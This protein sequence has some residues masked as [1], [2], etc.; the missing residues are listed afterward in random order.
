[1]IVLKIFSLNSEGIQWN[2]KYVNG[3][4]RLIFLGKCVA[5]QSKSTF[6]SI[7]ASSLTS[8]WIGDGE[9][10]VRALFTVARVHQPAVSHE[11]NSQI[12]ELNKILYIFSLT[13]D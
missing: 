8:K 11:E 10:M 4:N 3:F 12:C 9:K 13:V 7:S 5:S 6:F 2:S 1:M